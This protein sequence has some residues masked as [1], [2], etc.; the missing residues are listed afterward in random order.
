MDGALIV[1]QILHLIYIDFNSKPA[2]ILYAALILLQFL[3]FYNNII[4]LYHQLSQFEQFLNAL[5]VFK[6]CLSS[7]LYL[8]NT[9]LKATAKLPP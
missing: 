5:I 4:L 7:I 6:G 9:L 1:T 3:Q 2:G 8:Y